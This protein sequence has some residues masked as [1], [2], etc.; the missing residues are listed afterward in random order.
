MTETTPSLSTFKSMSSMTTCSLTWAKCLHTLSGRAIAF[1]CLVVED[2]TVQN[3]MA[4][5]F[6]NAAMIGG[7]R[8]LP[9]TPTAFAATWLGRMPEGLLREP[10]AVALPWPGQALSR[11]ILGRLRLPSVFH[12]RLTVP[13]AR[14]RTKKKGTQ[15]APTFFAD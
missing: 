15:R 3:A 8:C 13:R 6:F 4:F 14:L 12:D 2:G 9:Q 11:H 10:Q 1:V 7:R 5:V